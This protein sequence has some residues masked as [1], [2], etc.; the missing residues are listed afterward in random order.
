MVCAAN[1]R[2]IRRADEAAQDG[3]PTDG[4]AALASVMGRSWYNCLTSSGG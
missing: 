4:R 1:Q 3:L 2:T